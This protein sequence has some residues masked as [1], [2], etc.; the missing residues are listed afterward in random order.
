MIRKKR[1][2]GELSR[3]EIDSLI[4]AYTQGA[5]PDYQVSAWLMAV[6]LRG[7]TR[8]ETAAL[9]DAMLRSGEVLDLSR[10]AGEES[11]QALDGRRGRQDFPGVGA[12]GGRRGRDGSDD[13]RPRTGAHRR[14][15]RQTGG[16]SG[17]QCESA[18]AQNFGECS[19]RAA[20]P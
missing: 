6:V 11:G 7:M 18:S 15:A 4:A 17:I 8:G 10:I 3:F 19:R 5:I 1:D 12:A 16:D 13:Q 2:G 14:H 20:A 9:T